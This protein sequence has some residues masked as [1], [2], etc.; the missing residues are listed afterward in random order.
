MPAFLLSEYSSLKAG[1]VP[2]FW[3]TRYCIGVSRFLSSSSE[4]LTKIFM[5]PPSQRGGAGDPACASPR[6]PSAHAISGRSAI[7]A[8]SPIRAASTRNDISVVI[9]TRSGIFPWNFD[10]DQ[11]LPES[12]ADHLNHIRATDHFRERNPKEPLPGREPL[13]AVSPQPARR[14]QAADQ[15]MSPPMPRPAAAAFSFSG[16]SCTSASVI[17]MSAAMLAAFCRAVRVTLVGSMMPASNMSTHL[18]V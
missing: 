12:C 15:Y 7:D 8:T 10:S 9:V 2:S 18:P 4:G 17:S 1:S 14:A 5:L 13:G 6:T 3:V 11:G 16:S